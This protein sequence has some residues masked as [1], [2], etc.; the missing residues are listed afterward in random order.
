[1]IGSL[2]SSLI[3]LMSLLNFVTILLLFYGLAFC[4][5]ALG[6]SVPCPGIE[7]GPPAF[8]SAV[9]TPGLPGKSL[10]SCST[11]YNWLLILFC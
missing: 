1:M 6:I 8:K 10:D 5:Q 9:L 2:F 4:F 11:S 7:P 3:F